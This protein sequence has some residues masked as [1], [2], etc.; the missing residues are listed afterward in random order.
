MSKC[1]KFNINNNL[2]ILHLTLYELKEFNEFK[3]LFPKQG[4]SSGDDLYQ[5]GQ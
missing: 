3:C 1:G 5:M 4:N 2:Q